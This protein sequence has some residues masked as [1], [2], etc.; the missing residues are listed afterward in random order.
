[1]FEAYCKRNVMVYFIIMVFL[2]KY[3]T[4]DSHNIYCENS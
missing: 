3:I 1:M 2:S 4:C